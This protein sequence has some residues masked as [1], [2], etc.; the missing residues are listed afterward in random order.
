MRSKRVIISRIDGVGVMR[1]NQ[2]SVKSNDKISGDSLAAIVCNL[3][4]DNK[5]TY[6]QKKEWNAT[7]QEYEFPPY[8]ECDYVV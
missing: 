6:M 8:A 2:P 5:T 7:N 1:K 3:F 4:Y